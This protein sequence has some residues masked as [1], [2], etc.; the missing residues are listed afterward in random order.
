MGRLDRHIDPRIMESQTGSDILSAVT[1]ALLISP[2]GTML[3]A[4]EFLDAAEF[5][6]LRTDRFSPVSGFL[7]CRGVELSL[8]AFL[9]ARGM[10]W[11]A[12]REFRHDL[13]R[14][15]GEAVTCGFDQFV[16]LSTGEKEFLG[17]ISEDY[18]KQ[19]WAYFDIDWS[20]SSGVSPD[21]TELGLL[22]SRIVSTLEPICLALTKG[23]ADPLPLRPT[24]ERSIP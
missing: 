22:S 2:Y 5:L 24:A 14:L 9:R 15:L 1:G 11:G 17:R 3:R 19:R 23:N 4:R 6:R 7:A 21:S 13:N 12:V 10:P 16:P 20:L 8:K 18:A